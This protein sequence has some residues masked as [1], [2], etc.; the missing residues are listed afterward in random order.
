LPADH[1]FW[2]KSKSGGI[3]IEHGVH[4][5]DAFAWVSGQPGMIT[6]AQAFTNASGQEDRVEALA[7]YGQ[8]AA[9]FYH[10]FTHSS[11]NEQTTAR[12]TFER[13]YVTLHEW[14]PTRME[15]T[16]LKVDD[17]DIVRPFLPGDIHTE[18]DANGMI[19]LS[20]TLKEGK[21]AVYTACIQAGLSELAQ[22]VRYPDIQ[23]SVTGEQ[24]LASLRI[25]VEA[26]SIS[27]Q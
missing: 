23:L 14:V 26:E 7:S 22:A 6:A 15:L 25:A 19:S 4:F 24:G 5:F 12:L 1:W 20:A 2:D 11:A 27:R 13:G 9:H 17:A 18:A 16:M 21:A 8:T 10:G 3:W